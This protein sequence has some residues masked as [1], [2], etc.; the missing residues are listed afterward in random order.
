MEGTQADVV[1]AKQQPMHASMT[2]SVHV[3]A[4]W[5]PWL[6]FGGAGLVAL[7]VLRTPLAKLTERQQKQHHP[8]PSTHYPEVSQPPRHP[9]VLSI[10]RLAKTPL[11]G[12]TATMSSTPTSKNIANDLYHATVVG[13]LAIGYAKI[14][15][16]VFKGPMPR[17][18]LTPRGAGMVVLDLRI[19]SLPRTCLT[20]RGW[21]PLILSS[22]SGH[23]FNRDARQW[24]SG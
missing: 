8:A 19:R 22:S 5:T 14:G 17:L 12:I 16:M 1:V 7:Y 23:G 24:G 21:S 6:L 13:G 10:W 9:G 18:D 2:H 20:N 15:Q 4:D 3:K 11:Y